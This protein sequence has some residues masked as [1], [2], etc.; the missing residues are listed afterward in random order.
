[1]HIIITLT[2]RDSAAKAISTTRIPFIMLSVIPLMVPARSVYITM[3]S[4]LLPV[5]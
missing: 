4:S 3:S 1:M 5:L 2:T